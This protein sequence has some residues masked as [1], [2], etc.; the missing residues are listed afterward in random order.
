VAERRSLPNLVAGFAQRVH[1]DTQQKYP[2]AE[3]FHPEAALNAVT[4]DSVVEGD[5]L[6]KTQEQIFEA[7]RAIG[8]RFRD[9]LQLSLFGF[10]VIIDDKT[11]GFLV[12][13][14][15]Y[16]PSYKELDDFDHVLRRHIRQICER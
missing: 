14:V 8:A 16:F 12:I 13:D 6:A 10:D 15:N 5:N 11:G 3:D 4:T 7:V 1:F 9:Q 2:T